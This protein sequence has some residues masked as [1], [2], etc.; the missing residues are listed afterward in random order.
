MPEPSKIAPI[1]APKEVWLT[2]QGLL[3][4][5]YESWVNELPSKLRTGQAKYVYLRRRVD[6]VFW[7]HIDNTEYD[8]ILSVNLPSDPSSQQVIVI[9]KVLKSSENQYSRLSP[10]ENALL[11]FISP[12]LRG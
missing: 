10:G 12:Y 8:A 9:E 11:E 7:L 2:L 1:Q 5:Q 4:D 6:Q 3:S